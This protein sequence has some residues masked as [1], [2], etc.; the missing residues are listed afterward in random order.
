MMQLEIMMC[1]NVLQMRTYYNNVHIELLFQLFTVLQRQNIRRLTINITLPIIY[2]ANYYKWQTH[3]FSLDTII[4]GGQRQSSKSSNRHSAKT[5]INILIDTCSSP[6]K[7]TLAPRKK[8]HTLYKIVC[9]S[10]F[11]LYVRYRRLCFN[12]L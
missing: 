11:W 1:I 9:Y 2:Q 10:H 4:N 7:K 5:C 8:K 3:F 6:N 12:K